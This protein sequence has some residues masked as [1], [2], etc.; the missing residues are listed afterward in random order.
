LLLLLGDSGMTWGSLIGGGAGALAVGILDS[1]HLL[2]GLGAA[3]VMAWAAGRYFFEAQRNGEL[4]M[5]LCTPLGA[6]DIIAGNWRALS[7]PL[8]GAWL[9]VAFLMLAPILIAGSGGAPP[10]MFFFSRI[11]GPL[12]GV[13]DIIALCWVGMWFGLRARRPVSIMGW[14]VGLVVG[15]PW[16]ISYSLALGLNTARPPTSSFGISALA[17]FWFLVWPVANIIK[18]VLFIV[19][20]SHRL[21]GE[22]RTLA[23]LTVRDWP[24]G[25]RAAT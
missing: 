13:L 15:L 12:N 1:L 20:A 21:K 9:L 16:M 22:L 2:V 24:E 8:R 11:L 7:R 5:I 6:R 17:L 23:P 18:N 25:R 4:E 3:G 10:G 19:W 14:T